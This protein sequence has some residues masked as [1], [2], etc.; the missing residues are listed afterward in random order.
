M[1]RL[2]KQGAVIFTVLGVTSSIGATLQGNSPWASIGLVLFGIA[3]LVIL[4]VPKEDS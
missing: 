4:N 3:S 2:A 1:T